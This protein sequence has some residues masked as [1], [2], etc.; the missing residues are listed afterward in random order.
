MKKLY[1]IYYTVYDD[2]LHVKIINAIK[3]RYNVEIVD[4]RSRVHPEFRFIEVYTETEGLEEELRD[5]VKSMAG[6]MYVR[7]DWI[8]V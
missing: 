6:S 8:N 4:H 2:D 1:R 7:V 5:L 3:E